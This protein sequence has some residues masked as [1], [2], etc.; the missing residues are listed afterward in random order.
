M[1]NPAIVWFDQLARLLVAY[2]G[3]YPTAVCHFLDL[4]FARQFDSREAQRSMGEIDSQN[5]IAIDVGFGNITLRRDET[6]TYARAAVEITRLDHP[7][8]MLEMTLRVPASHH[9]P[10]AEIIERSRVHILEMLRGAV[11]RLEL[12]TAETLIYSRG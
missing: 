2:Q 6:G 1:I 3:A 7:A 9:E 8:D 11:D 5:G 4:C 10:L 12:E